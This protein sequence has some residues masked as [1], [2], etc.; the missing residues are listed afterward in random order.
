[1]AGPRL[2][3]Q[4][5][6]VLREAIQFSI[7]YGGTEHI[8]RM[9]TTGWTPKLE[10]KLAARQQWFT[11]SDEIAQVARVSRLIMFSNNRKA[12]GRVVPVGGGSLRPFFRSSVYPGERAIDALHTIPEQGAKT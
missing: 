1:M 10:R 9:L 11:A 8:A 2:N 4:E 3:D 6:A 5:R 12:A 7:A